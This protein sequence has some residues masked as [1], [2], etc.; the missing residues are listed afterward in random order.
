MNTNSIASP[1]FGGYR[2]IAITPEQEKILKND[3][4]GINLP[5]MTK[6]LVSDFDQLKETQN[7]QAYMPTAQ[8]DTLYVFTDDDKGTHGTQFERLR[9][10]ESGPHYQFLDNLRPEDQ[11]F[12]QQA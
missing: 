9:S 8:R 3:L 4:L 6:H 11:V 5:Y 12:D 1:R 10:G 7:A 2:K